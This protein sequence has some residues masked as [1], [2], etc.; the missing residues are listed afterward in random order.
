MCVCARAACDN[1]VELDV[2]SLTGMVVGN[3]VATVAIG[4]AVYLT[5]SHSRTNLSSSPRKSNNLITSSYSITSIII[6]KLAQHNIHGII[7]VNTES[8]SC[9]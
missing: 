3:L 8:H 2:L 5:V 6:F 9:G 1:C 4:V 7:S